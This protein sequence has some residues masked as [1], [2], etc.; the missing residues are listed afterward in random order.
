MRRS[1]DLLQMPCLDIL[2]ACSR[3]TGL[4]T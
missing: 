2:P 4:G 1:S 3:P